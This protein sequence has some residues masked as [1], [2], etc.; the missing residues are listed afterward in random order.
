MKL[1]SDVH[2][3]ELIFEVCLVKTLGHSST[4]IQEALRHLSSD[5]LVVFMPNRGFEVVNY[6]A[7][8]FAK[9]Y[10][11]RAL[12]ASEA[13][14]LVALRGLAEERQ[15]RLEQSDHKLTQTLLEEI[16][17]EQAR[18]DL[19]ENNNDF[20]ELLFAGCG[21]AKLL[22]M[23]RIV[24][25]IPFGIRHYFAF[26]DKGMKASQARHEQIF[27]AVLSR[28]ANRAA[29][30]ICEHIWSAKDQMLDVLPSVCNRQMMAEVR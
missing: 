10:S 27:R 12:L 23:I 16:I 30:L 24:T 9:I 8:D 22:R 6:S 17:S 15:E 3:G 18:C 21:K 20:L 28:Q 1:C 7:D 26:D 19:L 5:G 25:Q 13:I 14:W 29:A 2:I 11:F 4:P